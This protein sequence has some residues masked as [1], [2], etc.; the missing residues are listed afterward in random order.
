MKYEVSIKKSTFAT[1]TVEA[2][3][4]DEALKLAEDLSIGDLDFE[5]NEDEV[6]AIWEEGGSEPVWTA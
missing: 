6:L 1:A 2:D 3:S 4:V 5:D